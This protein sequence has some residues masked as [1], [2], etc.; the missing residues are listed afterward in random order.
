M[1]Q[2]ISVEGKTLLWSSPRKSITVPPKSSNITDNPFKQEP[3]YHNRRVLGSQIVPKSPFTEVFKLRQSQSYSKWQKQDMEAEAISKLRQKLEMTKSAM[4]A[5]ITSSNLPLNSHA[6]LSA[7]TTQNSLSKNTRNEG[8]TQPTFTGGTT[9]LPI[10][11]V[12]GGS[13][14]TL[15][16]TAKDVTPSADAKNTSSIFNFGDNSISSTTSTTSVTGKLVS[17]TAP[18]STSNATPSMQNTSTLTS[19]TVHFPKSNDAS[20]DKSHPFGTGTPPIFSRGIVA[21]QSSV[22]TFSLPSQPSSL[23]APHPHLFKAPDADGPKPN[24]VNHTDLGKPAS[25]LFSS[26]TTKP[27]SDTG[28]SINDTAAKSQNGGLTDQQSTGAPQPPVTEP[29]FRF[30]ESIK[31]ANVPSADTSTTSKFAFNSAKTEQPV[32][33]KLPIFGSNTQ[34]IEPTIPNATVSGPGISSSGTKPIGNFFNGSAIGLSNNVNSAVSGGFGGSGFSAADVQSGTG[35]SQAQNSA[36]SKT[37]NTF[38]LPINSGFGGNSFSTAGGQSGTGNLQSQ[39]SV[40]DKTAQSIF[41]NKPITGNNAFSS[42]FSG[43]STTN[44]DSSDSGKGNFSF[45]TS[46]SSTQQFPFKA[47]TSITTSSVFGKPSVFGTTTK[48]SSDSPKPLFGIASSEPTTTG[49]AATDKKESPQ[50]SFNFGAP[51][52]NEG[53]IGSFSTAGAQGTPNNAT[54]PNPFN[55]KPTTTNSFTFSFGTSSQGNKS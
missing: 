30:G 52:S 8:S 13:S 45:G 50:F 5:K 34:S 21:E 53:K 37:T 32:A 55:F 22:P 42:P 10:N 11:G 17:E 44:N 47:G 3:T 16:A 28:I 31:P 23:V 36:F 9:V 6:V 46:N 20:S 41:G 49:N 26:S 19:Q 1:L 35:S 39:N 51:A 40:F 25:S 4:A 33:S 7:P 12:K 24:A 18:K 15:P 29:T 38:A 43:S 27:V 54:N 14:I 48:S 2:D